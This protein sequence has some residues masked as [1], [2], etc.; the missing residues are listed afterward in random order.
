MAFCDAFRFILSVFTCPNNGKTSVLF[1]LAA[2][3]SIQC[4]CQPSPAYSFNEA[5]REDDR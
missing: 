2:L 1:D 4:M 5:I 3:P